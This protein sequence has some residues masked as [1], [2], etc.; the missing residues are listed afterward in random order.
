MIPPVRSVCAAFADDISIALDTSQDLPALLSAVRTYESG[1]GARI[2]WRKT[3]VVPFGALAA[4]TDRVRTVQERWLQLAAS[5]SPL[6]SALLEIAWIPPG[7]TTRYLGAP[8]GVGVS[9]PTTWRDALTRLRTNLLHGAL[10]QR[11]AT[12]HTRACVARVFG[13]AMLE[14]LVTLCPMS[15]LG[16]ADLQQA[17]TSFTLSGDAL[18]KSRA[19]RVH[20]PPVRFS[21]RVRRVHDG[22]IGEPL[23]KA[24]VA[25]LQAKQVV[26]ALSV[27]SDENDDDD[28]DAVPWQRLALEQMLRAMRPS[29]RSG[30]LPGEYVLYNASRAMFDGGDAG[31]FWHSA[32]QQMHKIGLQPSGFQTPLA[33]SLLVGRSHLRLGAG[34]M[35][36][37]QDAQAASATHA[38]QPVVFSPKAAATKRTT[39]RFRRELFERGY[40]FGAR[41][42]DASC[43][44]LIPSALQFF[45]VRRAASVVIANEA[46]AD[47][48]KE[49]QFLQRLFRSLMRQRREQLSSG[50]TSAAAALA[51]AE[52]S[53][54]DEEHE[55]EAFEHDAHLIAWQVEAQ[56][57]LGVAVRAGQ[58]RA[59]FRDLAQ[60]GLAPYEQQLRWL[61]MHKRAPCGRVLSTFDASVTRMCAWWRRA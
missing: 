2:N 3:A 10:R 32:L 47:R 4:N 36:N 27:L 34:S 35:R 21:L 28:V 19:H 24:R 9:V 61:L 54:D 60:P 30:V 57:E 37:D 5:T 49:N 52:Q 14:H 12:W 56:Q 18:L 40:S 45:S 11:P 8:C 26:R 13:G 48:L 55:I 22:G 44:V 7:E 46:L 50:S 31:G 59:V 38:S 15:Q 43:G 51:D 39:F 6:H 25:A 33:S 16:L 1:A 41:N 17:L 58:W 42:S 53:D 29:K 20:P 23:L